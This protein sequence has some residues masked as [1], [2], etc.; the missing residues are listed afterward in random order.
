MKEITTKVYTYDELSDTS[1]DR[2]KNWYLEGAYDY[3]WYEFIYDEAK[4]L[5]FTIESFDLYRRECEIKLHDT[6]ENIARKIV[7]EHGAV[8]DTH[9]TAKAFLL[10]FDKCPD[11]YE[12]TPEYENA[13]DEFIHALA[14]DYREMLQKESDYIESDEAIKEMMEAN[15][16][17]F[18][19]SG[20]RFG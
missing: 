7:A 6:P 13:R 15:E 11:E 10:A 16:Y 8:C 14:E 12:D 17:T 9:K 18:T 3:N 19:E 20:A 5:G 1:K 4:N 2:A